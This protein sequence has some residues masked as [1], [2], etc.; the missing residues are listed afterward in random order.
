MVQ[1][2]TNKEV[3][4]FACPATKNKLVSI[5]TRTLYNRDSSWRHSWDAKCHILY[6]RADHKNVAPAC[7]FSRSLQRH[8]SDTNGLPLWEACSTFGEEKKHNI[9]NK[10]KQKTKQLFN[11]ILKWADRHF[12]VFVFR[13]SNSLT[14]LQARQMFVKW[15]MKNKDVGKGSSWI[16]SVYKATGTAKED[17]VFHRRNSFDMFKCVFGRA[18]GTCLYNICLLFAPGAS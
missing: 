5:I 7:Y 11:L 3:L 4:D 9:T 10:N 6:Q 14:N 2:G 15:Q 1:Q 12:Y 13:N 16:Y 18:G 8:I 17:C